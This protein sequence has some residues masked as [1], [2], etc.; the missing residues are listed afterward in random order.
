MFSPVVGG[1]GLMLPTCAA[2]IFDLLFISMYGLEIGLRWT[3]GLSRI[4][5]QW[6]EDGWMMDG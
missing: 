3:D 4:K 5:R 2:Y 6:S 1:S